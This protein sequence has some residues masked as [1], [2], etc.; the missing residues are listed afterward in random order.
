MH[1]D[2]NHKRPGFLTRLGLYGLLPVLVV[3][4]ALHMYA[5][6]GRYI[7][8]ENAYI[9]ADIVEVS[10]NINGLVTD[11]FAQE[12]QRVSKG[13]P[14]FSIDSRPFEKALNIAKA[15]ITAAR[16]TI[17][18]L[19]A[20]YRLGQVSITAKQERVRYLKKKYERQ[21]GLLQIGSDTQAR[22]DEI[23]HSLN[24][25]KREL[26]SAREDNQM[27]LAE[28]VGKPDI[29]IEQHPLY[30]R[31]KAKQDIASLNLSYT[32]VSAPASG[33]LTH[34]SVEPGEYIETGDHLLA[35]VSTENLWVEA[36]L[37]EVDLAHLSVGQNATVV[38]DSLPDV[39]WFAT[40]D[41]ISP[42][43][44]A[45]FSVLPSQNAS[46]NW[47]KVVQR[48]P[49][50]LKLADKPGADSLRA[51]LTVTVSIDTKRERDLTGIVGKVFA[52]SQDP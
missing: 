5:K 3:G 50:R 37:K 51:G 27:V 39:E 48:I 9:K 41:S 42:A 16:Q 19:R 17:Q 29:A 7:T 4:A 36:N 31:A 14:V 40:V 44:G 52:F 28:L 46:G 10:T 23:E 49:V 45:E 6:G 18:S 20:H 30:L 22:F 26:A 47:V 12:N 43:T 1:D 35:I 33:I 38:L 32:S 21:E 24:M 13:D 2:K 11:V 34:V 8:T 25:A 15:D